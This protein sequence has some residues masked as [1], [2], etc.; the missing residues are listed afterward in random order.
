M[1]TQ[2]HASQD[3]RI[4]SLQVQGVI[5][6]HT[7]VQTRLFTYRSFR[8]HSFVTQTREVANTDKNVP[9]KVGDVMTKKHVWTCNPDTSIDDALESLV[10]HKI[11][12][13][14]VV[15]EEGKVVGVV[16]DYDMLTLD[17]VSGRME[18]AGIFPTASMDWEAFHEVQKLILKNTGKQVSDVMTPDPLVVRAETNIEAAARI[19]LQKKVRR[20]PVVDDSGRLIGMFTRG[21]VIKA[22]L[23][24]RK[25]SLDKT[26]KAK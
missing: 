4:G 17:N 20:L 6:S 9:E 11:T 21:D 14:P 18:A 24:A 8:T 10:E 26:M 7:H 3:R 1:S 5:E 2:T 12:G 16:S 13:L 22:A 25:A 19:L 23:R 15:D